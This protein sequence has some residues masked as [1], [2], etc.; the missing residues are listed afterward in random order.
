MMMVLAKRE[1][2]SDDKSGRNGLW[3]KLTWMIV[4]IVMT[5]W[6]TRE[7]KVKT[8]KDV[9]I[10]FF[11]F[12]LRKRYSFLLN[13]KGQIIFSNNPNNSDIN[14]WWKSS[15]SDEGSFNRI[16]TNVRSNNLAF[17]RT[18]TNTISNKLGIDKKIEIYK[19]SNSISSSN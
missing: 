8:T 9:V 3:N 18:F 12:H 13:L 1:E 19:I 4:A 16:Y 7:K 10:G 11:K 2:R 17:V 5:F 6:G 14:Y 15:F